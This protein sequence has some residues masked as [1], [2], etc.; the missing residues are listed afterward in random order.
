MAFA[1]QVL[2]WAR[3]SH[4]LMHGMGL[5]GYSAHYLKKYKKYGKKQIRAFEHKKCC[6]AAMK[7][8]VAARPSW[9]RFPDARHYGKGGC[10]PLLC[11]IVFRR[12][13]LYQ[14]LILLV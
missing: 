6:Q 12:F 11:V 14:N 2:W 3:E 1:T 10:R 9:R 7:R 5:Y 8:L 13:C 4:A